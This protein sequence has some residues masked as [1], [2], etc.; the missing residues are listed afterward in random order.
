MFAAFLATLLFCLSAI[1]ATKTARQLGGTEANFWRLALAALFLAVGAHLFGGGLRG[2]AFAIFLI[3]GC[4]GFG[5]GDLALFQ[6]LPRL[7]SRLTSL[8]VHCLAAPFAAICEWLW[9]GTTLTGQ[10][11]LCG[12]TILVGVAL[13]LAPSEHLHLERR[14]FWPGVWFGVLAALGQGFGAVLSRHAFAVARQAGENID[15]LTAAYQRIIG[16]VIIGGLFLLLVKRAHLI[17]SPTSANAG[18]GGNGFI[19]GMQAKW[20]DMWFWVALNALTGPSLGVAC[21]QWA[22]KTT[23]S[24]IVLP[25][26]ATMPLVIIPFSLK[27]EGE[28]P[29]RRSLV[30]GLIAVAGAVVLAIIRAS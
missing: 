28:K 4:V 24:G 19:A 11:I 5:I 20:R 26:V 29:T 27:M 14:I 25:I 12:S 21:F 3:S 30:G 22:L 15:G 8:L 10:E 23:P 18:S 16:G 17:G 7:G 1:A 9:L 13:A 2:A 6:S